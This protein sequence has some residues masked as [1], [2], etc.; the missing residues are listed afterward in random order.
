MIRMTSDDIIAILAAIVSV[1]AV[2]STFVTANRAAN[3][4]AFDELK[5]VV[6]MLND[7][8]KKLKE[9]LAERDQVIADLKDWAERL[10]KQIIALGSEPVKFIRHEKK[11]PQ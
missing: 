3:K 6:D 10:V 9:E 4:G 11:K 2:I 7:E 1:V 5:K 8:V